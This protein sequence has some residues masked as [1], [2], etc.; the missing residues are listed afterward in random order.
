M[1]LLERRGELDQGKMFAAITGGI[2][3]A[4]E[5]RG[6]AQAAEQ[7]LIDGPAARITA[8][9]ARLAVCAPLDARE[10]AAA[11]LPAVNT[12]AATY[13]GPINRAARAKA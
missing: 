5:W 10:A 2:S 13:T 1:A 3:S 6:Q 7:A 9:L 11:I 8:A 12:F 4:L